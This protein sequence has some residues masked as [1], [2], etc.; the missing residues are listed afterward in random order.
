MQL[1]GF[2]LHGLSCYYNVGEV[3]KK[4]VG[5]QRLKSINSFDNAIR[6]TYGEETEKEGRGRC[7]AYGG[8]GS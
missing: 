2:N 3:V 6:N 8:G 5:I 4:N 1:H 7:P